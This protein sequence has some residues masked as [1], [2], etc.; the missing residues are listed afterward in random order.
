MAVA[1]VALV[2]ALVVALG[3]KRHSDTGADEAEL[4]QLVDDFRDGRDIGPMSNWMTY[5]CSTDRVVIEQAKVTTVIAPSAH[6]DRSSPL[7]DVRSNR[8]ARPR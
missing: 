8:Q 3:S 4:D 1:V 2:I 7:I 5:Y 6:F